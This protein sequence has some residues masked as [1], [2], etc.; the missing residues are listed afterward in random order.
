MALVDEYPTNRL[1]GVTI[2][3][4]IDKPRGLSVRQRH[5]RGALNLDHEEF[6]GVAKP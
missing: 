4:I 5:A 3:A 1:I 2:S 6:D